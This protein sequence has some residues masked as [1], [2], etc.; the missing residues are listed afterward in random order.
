MLTRLR[1]RAPAALLLGSVLTSACAA[2]PALTRD[3]A[4]R[5]VVGATAAP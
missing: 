3:L 4:L 1:E 5:R 2:D